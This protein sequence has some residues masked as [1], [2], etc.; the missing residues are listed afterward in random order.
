M[1]V[2]S[3][4]KGWDSFN[5]CD[6]SCN[7]S[8]TMDH[9]DGYATTSPVGSFPGGESWVGAFDMIGNVWE[10]VYSSN[11]NDYVII[12][13]AWD[14]NAFLSLRPALYRTNPNATKIYWYTGFRLLINAESMP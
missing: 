7:Y 13:G 1:A 6:L 10:W 11:N 3:S 8:A 5:F 14:Y 12:G 4:R 9:N 2:S